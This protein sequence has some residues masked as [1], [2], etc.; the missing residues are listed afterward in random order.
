MI[1]ATTEDHLTTNIITDTSKTNL[2]K[3]NLESTLK[4]D[5]TDGELAYLENQR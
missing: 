4:T 1:E 3:V 5:N 2:D